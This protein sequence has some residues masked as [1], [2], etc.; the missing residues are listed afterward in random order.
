MLSRSKFVSAAP[1]R[2]GLCAA[3][4]AAGLVLAAPVAEATGPAASSKSHSGPATSRPK[5]HRSTSN[6]SAARL[7]T[8]AAPTGAEADVFEMTRHSLTNLGSRHQEGNALT[9]QEFRDGSTFSG[10][11][12]FHSGQF[13][14]IPSGENSVLLDGRAPANRSLR[15]GGH[16]YANGQFARL[17]NDANY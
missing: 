4:M 16:Q 15:N 5:P 9:L 12:D 17:T 11:M 14:A 8:D 7:D 10:V 6:P 2:A 13:L 1:V 3:V